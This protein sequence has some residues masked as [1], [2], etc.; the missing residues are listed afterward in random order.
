MDGSVVFE[1]TGITRTAPDAQRT[2]DTQKGCIF[3]GRKWIWA[4]F[5]N[6]SNDMRCGTRWN[7]TRFWTNRTIGP[8]SQ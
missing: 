2:V 8:R 3:C 4:G 1:Y 5:V 6:R 7:M